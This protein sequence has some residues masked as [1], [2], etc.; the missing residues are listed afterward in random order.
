MTAT[1]KVSSCDRAVSQGGEADV[2]T[3]V[4]WDIKDEEIVG[5]DTHH[6]RQQGSVA[7]DTEDLSDFIAY[8]AVT[9]ANAVAWAKT[10]LGSDEIALLEADV[11]TQIALSKAPVTGSGVPW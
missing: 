5:D 4:H 8:D 10:A 2:I 9:E 11:A 1:W 3:R 6:G 7:I